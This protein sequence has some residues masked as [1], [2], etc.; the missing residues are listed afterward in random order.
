MGL[1]W[2]ALG[3][4]I[5][6]S[7]AALLVLLTVTWTIGRAQHRHVVIDCAWGL[8]F[9]VVA[10]VTLIH[11]GMSITPNPDDARRWLLLAL[12]GLWGL[13][14]AIYLG[15]RMRDG[16]EDP[17]Y[18]KILESGGERRDL[19]AIRRVYLP[20]AVVLLL[21]SMVIQ[22]G[23]LGS[24]PLNWIAWLGVAV[25]AIGLFFEAAGD[26]QLSRHKNDPASRGTIL[27]TGVWRFTRHPNYFG[28]AAV[29]W[30][31]WLVAASAGWLVALV[32][33]LSPL[34]MTW[35][36]TSRTGKPL[37]ESRMMDR[38]GYREYVQRTSG[39][40][41]LPPRNRA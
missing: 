29:W 14:L 31:I 3:L 15:W 25:W 5:V 16:A 7:L 23:M 37:T 21:V 30:G 11:S 8:G 17:R 36:L 34:L 27:D 28:D 39:F 24:A 38:P 9:V 33:V 12:V 35:A 22:M 13:R 32:T 20:Q 41:P 6:L 18:E 10:V 2:S 26:L 40:F 1:S 4:N 19:Y